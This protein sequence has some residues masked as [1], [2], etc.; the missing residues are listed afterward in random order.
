[1]KKT[2]SAL[3]L[4]TFLAS[5]AL[6]QQDTHKKD[7]DHMSLS[8]SAVGIG[9]TDLDTS[10]AFYSGVLGMK[11]LVSYELD[12][13]NEIVLMPPDGGSALVLMQYTD[14]IERNVKNLPIKLVYRTSDPKALAQKIRDSGYEIVREPGPAEEVG[15]AVVGF[16]KGPDGYLIEILPTRN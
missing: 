7:E 11:S 14:G 6:A 1:M 12:Y 2:I 9:V 8:V 16:A 15:G 10:M 4:A 3:A 5:P 13:M